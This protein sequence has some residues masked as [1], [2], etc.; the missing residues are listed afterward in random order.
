MSSVDPQARAALEEELFGKHVLIT[1]REDWPAAEIIAG[2]RSQSEAGFS[3]RQ[4]AGAGRETGEGAC[5][6]VAFRELAVVFEGVVR[7]A[8][9]GPLTPA[10]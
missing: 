7:E 8:P 4:L 6:E 3:F 2:Y 10:G 1:S 9:S 5:A